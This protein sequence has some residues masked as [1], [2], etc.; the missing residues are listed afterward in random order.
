MIGASLCFE[1]SED[2]SLKFTDAVDNEAVFALELEAA[3]L[4]G[5]QSQIQMF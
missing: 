2:A 5:C 3:Q 4:E 1:K